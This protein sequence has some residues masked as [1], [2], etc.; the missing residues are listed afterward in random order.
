[1]NQTQF[2]TMA[3]RPTLGKMSQL[4]QVAVARNLARFWVLRSYPN[5]S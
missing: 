1:M 3:M 2:L 5:H 4:A